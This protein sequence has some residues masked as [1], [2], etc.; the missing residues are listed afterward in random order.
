MREHIPDTLF[1]FGL[2]ALATSVVVL[3]IGQWVFS[4]LNKNIPERLSS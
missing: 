3:V 1:S 4:T 2:L